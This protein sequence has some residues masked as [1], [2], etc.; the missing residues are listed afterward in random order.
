[1]TQGSDKNPLTPKAS[2]SKQIKLLF[3]GLVAFP[4]LLGKS[5]NQNFVN[6]KFLL[7]NF[8]QR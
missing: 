4:T 6:L 3:L 1:M 2:N 8:V 7:L 5:Y